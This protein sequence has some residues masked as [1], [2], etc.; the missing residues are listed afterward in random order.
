MSWGSAGNPRG[1]C[2]SQS[3]PEPGL[4]QDPTAGGMQRSP[5]FPP[6]VLNAWKAPGTERNA[7]WNSSCF[8][9]TAGEGI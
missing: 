2:T 8:P 3:I 1:L 6:L 7:L 9:N 4:Q 5:S